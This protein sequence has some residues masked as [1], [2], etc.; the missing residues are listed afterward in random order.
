ME[1]AFAVSQADIKLGFI[2][3]IVGMGVVFSALLLLTIIFNQIPRLL[4]IQLKRKV[5]K[6]GKKVIEKDCMQTIHLTV[7]FL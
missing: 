7:L 4:K 1:M 3:T 2:I 5:K 6:S